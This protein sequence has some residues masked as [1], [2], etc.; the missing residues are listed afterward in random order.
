MATGR[1]RQE[2][3]NRARARNRFRASGKKHWLSRPGSWIAIGAEKIAKLPSLQYSSVTRQL[4][5]GIRNRQKRGSGSAP[6]LHGVARS[7]FGL[8]DR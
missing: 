5:D 6:I 2:S 1:N 4:H 8:V 3:R 7:V